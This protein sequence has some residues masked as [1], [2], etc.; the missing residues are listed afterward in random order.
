MSRLLCLVLTLVIAGCAQQGTSLAPTG[1]QPTVPSAG[2]ITAKPDQAVIANVHFKNDTPNAAVFAVYW[3]Y[4]ANPF[5]HEEVRYC[6]NSGGQ[7][8]TGVVYKH[9]REGPQIRFLASAR[10]DCGTFNFHH[11][12]EI[13]F[14]E[15]NFERPEAD[16]HVQ[17]RYPNDKF[18]L[19]ARGAGNNEVCLTESHGH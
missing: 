12:I 16:L 6:V 11:D 7:F 1:L 19:C 15:M 17:Y 10:R 18:K 5:W 3:S 8:D 14:R 13:T 4:R 9:I 2:S